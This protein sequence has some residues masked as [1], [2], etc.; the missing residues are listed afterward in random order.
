MEINNYEN[1]AL[2]PIENTTMFLDSTGLSGGD[3]DLLLTLLRDY[4]VQGR[5]YPLA[6]KYIFGNLEDKLKK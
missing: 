3:R 4:C 1:R 2:T 5:E 6:E